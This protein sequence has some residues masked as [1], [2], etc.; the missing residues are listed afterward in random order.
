MANLTYDDELKNLLE[1]VKFKNFVRYGHVLYSD[2]CGT[3]KPEC[4]V[5]E[6]VWGWCRNPCF[7]I[8]LIKE[9]L[10][11]LPDFPKIL[12]RSNRYIC[13]DLIATNFDQAMVMVCAKTGNAPHLAYSI[14]STNQMDQVYEES[15]AESDHYVRL[16]NGTGFDGELWH[17]LSVN[18][19]WGKGVSSV[20]VSIYGGG[21]T[22]RNLLWQ[23]TYTGSSITKRTRARNDVVMFQPFKH[24]LPLMELDI[25]VV[26]QI[27]YKP[28]ATDVDALQIF[29][30]G[31]NKFC[32]WLQQIKFEVKLCKNTIARVNVREGKISFH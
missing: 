32:D 25:T 16:L 22:K 29:G 5:G 26:T 20:C 9:M 30:V 24:P 2:Y 10:S 21:A 4:T 12:G 11:I 27:I 31:S 15:T 7:A 13:S 3:L 8:S 28:E 17:G 1:L 23:H 14:E 19:E 6:L 18:Q